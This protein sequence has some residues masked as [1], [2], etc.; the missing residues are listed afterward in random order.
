MQSYVSD[1]LELAK[2]VYLDALLHCVAEVSNRDLET[3]RSRVQTQGLSFLTITL[4]NFC[5][6]FEKSLELGYVD[7]TFFPYFRKNGAI[8]AFLQGLLSRVFDKETGRISDYETP[9][10]K[11]RTIAT[12]E[13]IRQICLSFKKTKSDCTPKRVRK[14]LDGFVATEHELSTFQLPTES[15]DEFNHV[16]FMLWNRIISRLRVDMLVPRHG[17]G[18]TAERLSP[19]GKY[20]W[21]VWHDRLE[22][23]FPLIDSAYPISIGQV[24]DDSEE[25]NLVSIVA[26]DLEQPSRVVPVPKTLKGPRII[27]IEPC[28]MQYTQQSVKDLLYRVL[29]HNPLTRGHINFCDQSKN[30]RLAMTSSHD[31]QFVTIDLKDASDRV[32]RSLALELFSTNPV[33]LECIDACRSKR[34]ALPDG[35][36]VNL[37]KFASMGNAL[38]FPVEAMYFFTLC[39]MALLK[40]RN[41]PV[42][43]ATCYQV[44]RDV[45]VYGDDL[46]VP[47]DDATA[48]FDY[49]HRYNCKVNDRKTFY[50]GKFRESCGVDAYDGVE[51]TPTYITRVPPKNRRDA[52]ELISWVATANH[53]YKKGYYNTSQ[54]MFQHVEGILGP[55]PY[56]SENS[57]VLGRNY[58]GPT[59]QSLKRTSRRYH[60]LE[61]R[62]WV[63]SPVYLHDPLDGY[64]ALFKS[65]EKLSRL[66]TL[67]EPRD[68]KPLER[69]VLHGAAT[70]KRRWVLAI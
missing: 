27:A 30:Q 37:E 53:F 40:N 23:Y 66:K 35:R 65:L 32:P 64:A 9:H 8:P 60:A 51:V 41:L 38:C 22:P 62:A 18:N 24:V 67:N 14:T 63:P 16:S 2:R 10:Q 55:L 19:N 69:S 56:V 43:Y 44:A 46:I 39:V 70:L 50:R 29:E 33:L 12:I 54:Y 34:A 52:S 26:E 28:C 17:P 4:P 25:L 58:N 7:S 59:P 57:G 5:S 42:S 68:R 6:D 61:I 36:I 45:Y 31:G 15:R 49:L 20:R 1:Y 13:S 47:T 11:T 48:V 21:R 3:I